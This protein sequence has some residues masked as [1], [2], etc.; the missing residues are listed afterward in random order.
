[1]KFCLATLF[2]FLVVS[3]SAQQEHNPPA[4][5]GP[6]S[7]EASHQACLEQEFAAIERGEGFGMALPADR[8]GYPGPKHLLELKSELKLTPEQ[9]AAVQKLMAGTKE[10]ALARGH[11]IL[12]AEKRLDEMFSQYRPE[13][14]LREETYR[15]ASLRAEL[16]WIHLSAH[17]EARKL[18][19]AEQVAAYRRL[20]YGPAAAHT[21][22]AP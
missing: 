1:M 7:V 17:L 11:E 3:T 10:K 2:V 8:N 6:A 21:H 19:T 16:R 14:E 18:L 13:A 9:E 20:R 12:L 15:I 22:G 4:A 5:T